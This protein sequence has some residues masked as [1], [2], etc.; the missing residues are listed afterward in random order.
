MLAMDNA[1]REMDAIVSDL[2]IKRALSSKS[3]PGAMRVFHPKELV[4]VYR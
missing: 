3:P 2:R 1:R 4:R